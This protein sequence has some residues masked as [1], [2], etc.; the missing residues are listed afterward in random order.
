MVNT[1]GINIIPDND[2]E[3]VETLRRYKI[4]DTPPENAFD[5]VARLAAQIFQVPISLISLVDTDQV[6]FKAN[7][8]M[9]NA[10]VT[11]RGVSLC[12]L[13]ILKSE[14]TVFEDA[15]KEPCL[16]TNPNVAGDFG[17]KFY[18]GAPLTTNDGY[19]IGTL[20]VIDKKPRSFSEK[21]REILRGLAQ[22]VMDEVEL[23]LSALTEADKLQQSNEELSSINEEL[24]TSNEELNSSQSYLEEVNEAL[25]ESESRFRR[26]IM[27][28]PVA[29]A[30]M[31]G[32]DLVIDCA[33]DMILKI[34]GKDASVVGKPLSVAL[35]ELQGQ[36]FLQI[37]DNVYTSGEAYYGTE[38]KVMLEQEG[39]LTE[40][41]VNFV[42]QP[43]H[44]IDGDT[45]SIMVVASDVTDQ[46]R[47][48]EA[49]RQKNEELSLLAEQLSYVNNSIPQQV[50]TAT[51]DGLL[52]F[53]N[54]KTVQYFE[55]PV[56]DIIGEKWIQLVHPDDLELAGKAWAHSLSTGEPYQTEFRLLSGDGSYV[57]HLSRATAYTDNGTIKKWFGTNTNIDSHKRLEQHK[58]DF[59]SIASHE[60]KTPITSLK[61]SL[62]LMQRLIDKPN[63][64]MMTKMIEQSNR[65][66]IKVSSLVD[67]LLSVSRISAGQLHVKKTK[68]IIGDLL[69]NASELVVS[70][71]GLPIEFEGFLETEV[72]ADD[73]AIEQV[74]VNLLNNAIKYAP[75][76]DKVILG[77]GTMKEQVKI[78]VTD[79][80]PGIPEDKLSHL[81]DRYYRTDHSG[82][83]YS[84]LGL[85]L[86]ICAEII[87]RHDGEIIV[88]SE[89]GKGSTFSF[90]LPLN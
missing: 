48:K 46:V 27:Q 19:R 29:I 7:I 42:Y 41:F 5:N 84:G 53:V 6:F 74:V 72:Y 40:F 76:S 80:G 22:I 89:L 44:S 33:N 86:Y 18:A 64:L 79:F 45:T 14:V 20:C 26:L 10:R 61:A 85:G 2:S 9:G 57:W 11:T 67:D 60:L 39:L 24:H 83:Q 81:F 77:V 21:D 54:E 65:G 49:I 75:N 4:L 12:S 38:V 56:S 30:S 37:L 23:R 70:E 87:K 62:Q 8:G 25:A 50:W 88:E 3:R 36:P 59:I 66:I 63:E 51:P 47:S 69:K 34:W 31:E 43:I 17:L 78:T 35:P 28:S 82:H 73:H 15:P 58:N 71:N 52:D 68:F 32:R 1:F 90:T 13:A 16:L 55:K